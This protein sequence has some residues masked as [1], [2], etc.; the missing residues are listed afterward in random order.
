M[1]RQSLDRRWKFEFISTSPIQDI[2]PG[3]TIVDLPHDFSIIQKRDPNTLSG[4]SNGFFPGGIGTYEKTLFVPNE[5]KGKKVMLEFEGAYMNTTVHINRELVARH[6]YGYTSFHCDLTPYLLYDQENTITVTVNN[7]ALPNTRWYSGS[8]LYRHVWLMI[9]ESV[10]ITPWGIFA[11]TPDVSPDRSRVH[12]KTTIENIDTEPAEVTIRSTLLDSSGDTVAVD[13]LQLEI[14][15]GTTKEVEQDLVVSPANLWSVDNPYLYTLRSEVVKDGNVI[16]S[17]ETSIGIRSISFDTQNG[18]MLNGVPMKLKGGCVHHDCGLLGAA[19]YDRAEERKVELLKANGFNAVRC[20][21]NPPSPAFLDA[22]DRLGMLVIDEAFDCWHEGKN[23]NDYSVYFEDWWKKDLA[24]MVLRDRNHP[25]IIMWSTGNENVERFGRSE[26]YTYARKLA[27][28]VRNLDDTR[29]VTNALCSFWGNAESI[30]LM[31][32]LTELPEGFDLWAEFT[33]EFA[34]PLDVVGYNY[35]YQRYESDGKRFPDRIMYGSE[36][37]PKEA[38]DNWEAVERLPYVIGDFVWTSLD[39]LGEAGIGHVWYNGETGAR[40]DYPW[41]QAYCG[42]IDICGFKRPQS[43]YRDCV[44]GISK[45]PYIAVYKMEH[46]GK[47]PDISPWGWPDVVSSW[48][49]PGFEGKPTQVDVYCMDNE[50]ELILNGKSLGRKPA[51]KANRYL[52][53]FDVTYEPGTLEA[54]AYDENGVET[55]RSVL[56]TAGKPASIRLTPDRSRLDAKFGDLSFITV[57]VLDAEG[58]L[59]HNADTNIYF[60]ASGVGSVL[61]VGSGNPVTEEMYVG[62]QRRVYYGRAMVVLR[63]DGDPGTITLTASAEGIPSA[64]VEIQVG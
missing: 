41:H 30:V 37:F 58:N 11:T 43:Y 45:A 36:T 24:S 55:S 16:D 14:D 26:G 44:W 35:L 22:C 3:S 27:D 13:E 52:A 60:T 62:N 25:C 46:Y 51:G 61:A 28:F 47:T 18:F 40:G 32:K 12:V 42:D 29:P 54:V 5:W 56:K 20:A 6:P 1:Q 15:G 50:V 39:Y 53:S 19:A 7:S 10:H 17:V 48:T 64:T 57:E 8:G 2:Q 9:G 63:A 21:H 34:E 31:D 23:P 33:R 38:F 49:W 59:V 4:S